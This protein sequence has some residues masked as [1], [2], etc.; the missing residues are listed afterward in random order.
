[1]DDALLV[2]RFK[3]VRDLRRDR[4]GLID[5]ERSAGDAF[6]Q[7]LAIHQ[8]HDERAHRSALFE[9]MNGRNMRV[10]ERGKDLRFALETGQSLGIRGK[11]RRK[12]LQR[13]VA[14]KARVACAIHL[15]HSA[16]TER[17]G[18]FVDAD[19]LTSGERHKGRSPQILSWNPRT[20]N[21]EP[22]PEP[23]NHEPRTEP[24]TRTGNREPGSVN[25]GS[26]T[27]PCPLPS[28]PWAR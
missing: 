26:L 28:F 5:G 2:C 22:N 24:R 17:T 3:R 18:D 23:P 4:Q 10:I 9:P 7:C 11:G 1:M 27:T 20:M 8:L 12:N 16:S 15:A 25:Y 14:A 6:G 19:L 13:D 21:P